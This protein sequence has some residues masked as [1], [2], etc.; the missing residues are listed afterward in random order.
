MELVLLVPANFKPL[1]IVL[2]IGRIQQVQDAF[3]IDLQKAHIDSKVL[4]RIPLH[5]LEHELYRPRY[6]PLIL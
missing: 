1:E 5:L 3:V 6:Y 2:Q 4:M